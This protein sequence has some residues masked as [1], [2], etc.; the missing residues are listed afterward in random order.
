MKFQSSYFERSR[1]KNH[2]SKIYPPAYQAKAK[3]V[4]ILNRLKKL[5]I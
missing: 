5:R 1:K 2:N 3:L 4:T